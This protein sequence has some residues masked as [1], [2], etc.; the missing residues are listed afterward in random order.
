MSA[1]LLSCL[2]MLL[3]VCLA[4]RCMLRICDHQIL[5]SE[6]AVEQLAA[7]KAAPCTS[8]VCNEFAVDL[9]PSVCCNPPLQ[10]CTCNTDPAT[11]EYFVLVKPAAVRPAE[12]AAFAQQFRGLLVSSTTAQLALGSLLRSAAC[13]KPSPQP[14]QHI[15]LSA[16]EA[17]NINTIPYRMCRLCTTNLA[18]DR[19]AATCKIVIDLSRPPSRLRLTTSMEPASNCCRSCTPHTCLFMRCASQAA[20]RCCVPSLQC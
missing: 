15:F 5:L 13:C 1:P 14:A 19:S 6:Q 2:L 8:F 3:P 4:V 20:K 11:Q 10:G 18:R 17:H 16:G 9:L 7:Q 12:H